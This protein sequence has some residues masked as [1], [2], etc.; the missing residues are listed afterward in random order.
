MYHVLT[1]RNY[2]VESSFPTLEEAI[3]ECGRSERSSGDNFARIVSHQ[4]QH[5]ADSQGR[6]SGFGERYVDAAT[7]TG[8][9][10]SDS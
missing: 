4:G 2:T 1:C 9:Y 5:V 3:A 10:D 6:Y 7:R 8:M